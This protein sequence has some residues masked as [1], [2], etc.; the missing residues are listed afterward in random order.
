MSEKIAYKRKESNVTAQVFEPGMET[1]C[2]NE[3]ICLQFKHK[4]CNRETCKIIRPAMATMHGVTKVEP[5]DY[6]VYYKNGDCTIMNKN[7][8]EKTYEPV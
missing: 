6:V 4:V 2:L 8:F 3:R 7:H 1:A 5:G